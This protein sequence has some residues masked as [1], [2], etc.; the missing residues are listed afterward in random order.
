MAMGSS[1]WLCLGWWPH[2][3][4]SCC[5]WG[6]GCRG[7]ARKMGSVGFVRGAQAEGLS[8]VSGCGKPDQEKFW[9]RKVD[10]APES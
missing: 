1:E 4:C 5:S 10:S 6:G 2:G 3:G 9:R 7:S 8:L